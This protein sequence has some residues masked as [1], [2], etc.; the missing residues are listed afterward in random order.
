[1][2][3]QDIA[4]RVFELES[5]AIRQLGQ[6][7]DQRFDQAVELL[8]NCRGR[9]IVSGLGKSG[10]VGKKI[11]ATLSSTGT[12][13]Y[14]LHPAD[15]LHGDLGVLTP[16][17]CLVSISNSG[18]TDELLQLLP[19]LQRL[20]IP[21]IALVGDLQ[22]SLARHAQIALYIGVSEE[23]SS[24]AAVPMAS[25]AT[26]LAMGD[27]LA[28]ALM[29]LKNFQYEDFARLHPGGSLG[30]KLITQVRDR[31]RAHDLPIVSPDTDIETIIVRLSSGMLGTVAVCDQHGIIIGIITDGDLRRAL[32]RHPNASFFELQAQNLLTL[33][34]KTIRPEQTLLE[35]EQLMQQHK[36][37]TLLVADAEMQLVGMLAKHFIA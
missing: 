5:A 25:V 34:P 17:D 1:M 12:P 28:A 22:S 14:F 20:R 24:V 16:D 35:A 27:A 18:E 4:Y 15:A 9:V 37:T 33:H 10:L 13:S 2:N 30:R 21:H 36:I 11:A 8:N 7:L 23:A 32:Q 31:M 6:Q 29:S 26:S 3:L 19:H